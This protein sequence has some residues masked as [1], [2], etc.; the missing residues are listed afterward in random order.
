MANFSVGDKLQYAVYHPKTRS[1]HWHYPHLS[2]KKTPGGEP[3][4][5]VY[6]GVCHSLNR[7]GTSVRVNT[8]HV[9]QH[10]SLVAQVLLA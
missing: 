10:L 9:Y 6:V 3:G 1:H 8:G 5:Y 2:A 7:L 4:A